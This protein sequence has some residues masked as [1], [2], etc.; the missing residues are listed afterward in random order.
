MANKRGKLILTEQGRQTGLRKKKSRGERQR[1]KLNWVDGRLGPSGGGSYVG[2]NIFPEWMLHDGQVMLSPGDGFVTRCGLTVTRLD[3]C[4]YA[5][6]TQARGKAKKAPDIPAGTLTI[7][8]KKIR[9]FERYSDG[10]VFRTPRYVFLIDTGLFVLTNMSS[11]LT[12]F[13]TVIAAK[14]AKEN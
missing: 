13:D 2:C 9:P 6:A 7:F 4:E 11:T 10:H 5:Q 1:P 8:M 3:N 12:E 14:E